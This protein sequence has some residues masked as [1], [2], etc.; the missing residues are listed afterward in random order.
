LVVVAIEPTGAVVVVEFAVIAVV[1]EYKPAVA[2][3]AAVE[4]LDVNEAPVTAPEAA[5]VAAVT[6]PE[7]ATLVAVTAANVE[8]P[9]TV[10]DSNADQSRQRLQL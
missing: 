5:T 6:A 1:R 2:L 7:A 8:A 4:P 10:T 9:V 3:A